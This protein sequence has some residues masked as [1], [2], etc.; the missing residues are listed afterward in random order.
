VGRSR[1]ALGAAVVLA[2][3]AAVVS[4]SPAAHAQD[5]GLV[6]HAPAGA[7]AAVEPV[8][9]AL[10]RAA[11]RSG[12]RGEGRPF[13][14]AVDLLAAGAVRAGRLDGFARVTQLAAEG[15]RGYLEAR[16]AAAAAHLGDARGEAAAL[17]D[18]AGGLEVYAEL[19]LRLGAVELALGREREAELDFRLAGLL[20]PARAVTDAEFKPAVVDRFR[21]AQ[22]RARKSRRRRIDAGPA[23]IAIEVDGRVLGQAPVDIDLEDGLHVLV[24]RAP[25]LTARGQVLAVEASGAAHIRVQLAED[26]LAAAVAGAGARMRIGEP[27]AGAA[28]AAQA[29]IAVGELDG[30]LVAAS[31]WRRGEPALLGQLCQGAPVGCGPVIEIGYA[32]S[33]RLE[34]AADALWRQT[35]EGGG[36]GALTL[37]ADARLVHREPPPDP[38]LPAGGEPERWWQSRWLW[39]GVGGAA[40]SAVA[41][42]L[43]LSGGDGELEWTLSSDGCQFGRC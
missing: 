32:R 22:G 23:G 39:V 30:V 36:G 20:D 13:S 38:R 6:V 28:D 10:A 9:A 3:L 25:G 26:P 18:L 41:A 29:L 16:F 12:A 21:A 14:R 35:R 40:L 15:W 19:C 27:A 33:D 24:A 42:G 8:R 2:V 37:L 4:G 43:M 5:V 1:R 17:L 34:Q 11:A 31:V 7:P